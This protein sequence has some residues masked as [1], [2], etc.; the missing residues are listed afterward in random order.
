MK[1]Y[2]RKK[3]NCHGFM[4]GEFQVIRGSRVGENRRSQASTETP[5]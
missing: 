3:K 5:A 4:S 2:F 1:D